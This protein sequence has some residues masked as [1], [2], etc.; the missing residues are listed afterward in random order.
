MINTYAGTPIF[1][2]I[3][4][5]TKTLTDENLFSGM[6]QGISVILQESIHSGEFQEIY[7][8]KAVTLVQKVP[9]YPIACVL[10]AT[11][12][13][14]SLRDGLKL[15]AERF[16]AEF[17]DHFD[18]LTRVDQFSGAEDLVNACFPHVPIYD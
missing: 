18:N 3:W 15:F 8:T 16:L 14:R 11:R 9:D 10:I 17:S 4:N 13:T 5:R 12:P 2:H 6:F 7:V 1:A